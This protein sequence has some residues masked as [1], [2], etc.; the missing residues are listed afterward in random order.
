MKGQIFKNYHINFTLQNFPKYKKN[1][2]KK[3]DFT[4]W[5]SGSQFG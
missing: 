1:F 3:T 5:L 4:S 2:V